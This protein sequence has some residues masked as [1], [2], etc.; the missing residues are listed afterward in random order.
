MLTIPATSAVNA[1]YQPAVRKAAFSDK[2]AAIPTRQPYHVILSASARAKS[3]KLEGYS[4]YSIS[5]KLGLDIKTVS[6]FLDISATTTAYKTTSNAPKTVTFSIPAKSTYTA[7]K[8]MAF[9]VAPK[10]AYIAQ[11]ATYTAPKEA[12]KEPRATTQSREQLVSALQLQN[13]ETIQPQP[14]DENTHLIV[15]LQSITQDTSAA[16]K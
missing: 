14:G 13:F 15:P 12:Y 6:Q 4:L 11:K 7:P 3:M 8:S 16:A 1:K 2:T 10:A 5:L 9:S